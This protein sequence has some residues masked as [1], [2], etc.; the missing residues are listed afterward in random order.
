MMIDTQTH[1]SNGITVDIHLCGNLT[2]KE[3]KDGLYNRGALRP[4]A[5]LPDRS[6]CL[7]MCN[8]LENAKDSLSTSIQK[9][10]FVSSFE[11]IFLQD[12][13]INERATTRHEIPERICGPA[14]EVPLWAQPARGEARLEVCSST[15][16]SFLG[17]VNN[18]FSPFLQ[19]ACES[20]GRQVSVDLTTRSSF[21]LGRSPNSEIQLLHATSSRKHAILFHHSNGSCYLVDCGSAHGTYVNGKRVASPCNGVAIPHKVKK[22]S[23][24]RFGG[25]GSPCFI[26]KSFSS[27]VE[28][29]VSDDCQD[30]G[31]LVRRN[32]RL[33]ATGEFAKACFSEPSDNTMDVVRKRSFDSLYT[34]DTLEEDEC[35]QFYK[36]MRCS[37]PPPSPEAPIRLVSP[38]LSVTLISKPRRVTFSLDPPMVFDCSLLTTTKLLSHIIDH[39][40]L[41]RFLSVSY[42]HSQRHRISRPSTSF[43]FYKKTCSQYRYIY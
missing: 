17:L 41:F 32:T 40:H 29:S 14:M 1:R 10:P 9:K 42:G 43:Q 5:I 27:Y 36:R 12:E 21:R 20:V 34:T 22:G 4:I 24:I 19:P 35:D 11:S 6:R 15:I 30:T 26:L 3:V 31:V 39:L 2:R 37:S 18:F 25:P 28:G 33:N 7:N 8:N 16:D 13:N 38:E 23:L